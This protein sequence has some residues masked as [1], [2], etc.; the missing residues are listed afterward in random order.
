MAGFG[1]VTELERVVIH[2]CTKGI[3]VHRDEKGVKEVIHAVGF[4]R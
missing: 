2:H 3:L 4:V 1:P